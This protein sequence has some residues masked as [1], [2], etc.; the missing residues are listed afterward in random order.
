MNHKH[1]SCEID[2]KIERSPWGVLRTTA[3]VISAALGALA[4]VNAFIAS[5]VGALQSGLPGTFN[6]F[7]SRS[8]DAAYVVA[9]SGSPVLLLHGIGA[10]NSMME[11]EKN[12]DALREQHTVYAVDLLGWGRSDRPHGPYSPDE[13]VDLIQSFALNVIGEP[14]ALIASSDSCSYAIEAAQQSPELFSQMVLV[15]P[16]IVPEK[17]EQSKSESKA[18]LWVF[19]LPVVGQTLHNVL[20]SRGAIRSFAE[21]QLYFDK[22]RV[23]DALVT[24]YYNDAHQ[25]GARH[26]MA[27]FVSGTMRHD[28]LPAWGRLRQPALL[29]WGRNTQINAVE[30]APEWLAL[31]ADAELHVIDNALLLPHVEHAQEWNTLVLGWLETGNPATGK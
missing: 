15:C 25:P 18:I 19:E 12:F 13:Y 4:L 14:C 26:G 28:A 10:G 9:G 29:V 27:S 20:A 5:R 17:T 11:W 30:T 31:K 24:R 16:S 3:T 2:H 8:G 1:I 22:E 21:H 6:R 7:P 23:T